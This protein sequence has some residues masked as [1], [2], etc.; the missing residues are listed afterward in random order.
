MIFL[1]G[2]CIHKDKELGILKNYYKNETLK[3]FKS[4]KV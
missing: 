4:F 1:C 2:I 3:D